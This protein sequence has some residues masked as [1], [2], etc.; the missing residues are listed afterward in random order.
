MNG[1]QYEFDVSEETIAR[2]NLGTLKQGDPVNLERALRL[3]DRLGGH[4]VSGHIDAVGTVL[5]KRPRLGSLQFRVAI[6]ESLS[7]YLV[8]KGSVAV[9]GVSL[10]VNE[11]GSNFFEV[12]LIPHTVEMTTLQVRKEGDPVNIET[13]LVGKYVER[14]LRSGREDEQ[15]RKDGGISLESLAKSGFL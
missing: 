2:S 9:D 1:R 5:I 14:I 6:P 7:R 15:K 8:P 4:L 11:C 3:S 12:N 10:T 13:D